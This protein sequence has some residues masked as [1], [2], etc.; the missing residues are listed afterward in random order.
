MNK[1]IFDITQLN[2]WKNLSIHFNELKATKMNDLFLSD[3]KRFTKFSVKAPCLFLDYSKNHITDKTISLLINFAQEVNL[4][5]KILA[6]FDGKKINNTEDRAVLHTALRNC[7]NSPVLVDGIDVMPKINAVLEKMRIFSEKVRDGSWCG[8]TGKRIT[9]V[10]S[11]GIGGSDLGPKMAAYALSFYGSEKLKLHFVSNIDGT[12]ITETLKHLDPET[13]LFSIASKTFTTIETL[14]NAHTARDWFLKHAKDSKVIAKHFIAISTNTKEVKNF[15]ID[16]ANMFEFWDWVGGRYSI[17]SAIGLPIALAVGFDNF[18]GFLSGANKMDLH[19][20]NSEFA[21]NMPAILGLLGFWYRNFYNYSSYAVIPYDQYLQFLPNYLQQLDMES[22]GK[23]VKKDAEH[24]NYATGPIIWGGIGTDGQHAFHQLLHQGTDTI[25]IDFII[26]V[27]S[28]NPIGEHHKLLFANCLAQSQALLQGKSYEIAL[29]ELLDKG[30]DEAQAKV[31]AH[32]KVM[33][34]NRPSNSL[35][36]DKLTPEALGAIIALYEQ[37]V[38]V[39]GMLWQINSFD[40]W[41][42][43]LGKQLANKIGPD[44]SLKRDCNHNQYDSSTEG[45]INYYLAKTKLRNMSY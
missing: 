35:L 1:N 2:S 3:N 14:T 38:F 6:M 21:Q 27:N 42:V 33:P 41:G 23:S 10:V 45:L 12:Q 39:Q 19:F 29:K 5:E 31:L 9:D 34:G 28:L 37:K 24:V 20:K 15:G 4:Q 8:F 26:P 30:M 43:E 13:T 18:S 17:W 11:I 32:H 25:P 44:L 7:D 22:N 16:P 36:L 40:Q